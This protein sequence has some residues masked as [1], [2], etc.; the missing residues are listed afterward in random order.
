MSVILD[1]CPKDV[2]EQMMMRLSIAWSHP[3]GPVVA[4]KKKMALTHRRFEKGG[5]GTTAQLDYV[6]GPRRT[7]DKEGEKRI[8]QLDYIT[9]PR[10]KSDEAYIN[11][12]VKLLGLLG[13]LPDLRCC[14]EK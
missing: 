13:P 11:H 4:V 3:R 7:L 5:K 2:K 14:T 9:G 8:A 6:V 12:D 10:W 1:I